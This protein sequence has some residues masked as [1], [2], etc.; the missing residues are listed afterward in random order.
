MLSLLSVPQ[1]LRS[2][3]SKFFFHLLLLTP[4][5]QSDVQGPIVSTLLG[6]L[7]ET[8]S[9]WT[10][11]RPPESELHFNK[12]SRQFVCTLLL[13]SPRYY[14]MY[15]YPA[16]LLLTAVLHLWCA[17]LEGAGPLNTPTSSPL[18][19]QPCDSSTPSP[20]GAGHPAPLSQANP[21][22]QDSEAKLLGG[23]KTP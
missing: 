16:I 1:S 5:T 17:I 19:A 21:T 7:L 2:P 15:L 20:K 13:I 18:R 10:H 4:T 9:L 8:Q 23:N 11:S 14:M 6:T 22:P 12:V 3:P